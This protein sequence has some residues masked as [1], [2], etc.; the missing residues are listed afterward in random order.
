MTR[1]VTHTPRK[2]PRT[3]PQETA[4]LRL[5]DIR[6][7]SWLWVDKELVDVFAPLIGPY[8]FAVY[9][10]L[11]HHAERNDQARTEPVSIRDLETVW[12]NEYADARATL[13]R[14]SIDRAL[15]QLMAAGMIL[16]EKEARGAKPAVYA[17]VSLKHVAERLTPELREN[18][19]VRMEM[20]RMR[21]DS[22]V[23]HGDTVKPLKSSGKAC[24]KDM[25]STEIPGTQMRPTGTLASP[26]GDSS[27]DIREKRRE[28][29]PPTPLAEGGDSSAPHSD[30]ARQATQATGAAT[31][32]AMRQSWHVAWSSLRNHFRTDTRTAGKLR[33]GFADGQKEWYR[34]F[35]SLVLE[36]WELDVDN[37]LELI[38]S[39]E[40]PAAANAGFTK[41][42][43]TW[44]GA[45]LAAFGQRVQ[46]RVVSAAAEAS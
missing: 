43:K 8:A 10:C 13:S 44:N 33:S 4:A 24:V 19:T 25:I 2:T 14:S 38:V 39:S 23:P 36:R 21:S 32:V 5:R 41:Y 20:Q 11:A 37:R 15:S 26:A 9:V 34:C 12:R 22:T 45:L 46:L 29:Y 42:A 30:Q 31:G 16:R 17:L 6:E 7:K 40:N 27:I 18:L 3:M 28:E 1:A 35:D